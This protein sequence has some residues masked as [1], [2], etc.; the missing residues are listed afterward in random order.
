MRGISTCRKHNIHNID[1]HPNSTTPRHR[2]NMNVKSFKNTDD[3]QKQ[4]TN[5]Y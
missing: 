4:E 1:S 2:N 5:I 3:S